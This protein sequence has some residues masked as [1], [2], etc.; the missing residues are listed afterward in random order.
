M[1]AHSCITH[2]A[3]LTQPCPVQPLKDRDDVRLLIH[4]GTGKNL[5]LGLYL[6]LNAHLGVYF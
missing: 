4:L 3:S 1:D 6:L 2:G 5:G